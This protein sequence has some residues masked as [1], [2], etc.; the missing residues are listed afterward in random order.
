MKLSLLTK[1]DQIKVSYYLI[2]SNLIFQNTCNMIAQNCFDFFYIH[3]WN[4]HVQHS[5]FVN[6]M[7]F[8]CF[9]LLVRCKVC[10]SCF[11]CKCGKISASH[12]FDGNLRKILAFFNLNFCL[13]NWDA[14][15]FH[16]FTA[17][18]LLTQQIKGWTGDLRLTNLNYY[19]ENVAKTLIKP[20][21]KGFCFHVFAKLVMVVS[22]KKFEMK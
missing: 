16:A 11:N 6:F 17:Q 3:V 2:K 19:L 7:V 9:N 1:V 20:M 14:V 15:I 5:S 10:W 21:C 12:V 4:V 18:F 13:Q 8:Q 22:S